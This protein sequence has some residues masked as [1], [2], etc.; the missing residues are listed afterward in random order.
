ML[1]GFIPFRKK[2]ISVG[3]VSSVANIKKKILCA[4]GALGGDL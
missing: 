2:L 4:L 3:A 1:N